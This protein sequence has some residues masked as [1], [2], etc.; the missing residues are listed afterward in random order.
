MKRSIKDAIAVS[1]K[2]VQ[3]VKRREEEQQVADREES[4]GLKSAMATLDALGPTFIALE[5]CSSALNLSMG[6]FQ[7]QLEGRLPAH[8]LFVD[9]FKSVFSQYIT[10]FMGLFTKAKHSVQQTLNNLRKAHHEAVVGRFRG[11]KEV[12]RLNQE[13]NDAIGHQR[14]LEIQ[15]LMS[16]FDSLPRWVSPTELYVPDPGAGS[17]HLLL[18]G[19]FVNTCIHPEGDAHLFR[20]NVTPTSE[21]VRIAIECAA[22]ENS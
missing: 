1:S 14:T 6:E 10:E 2:S 21:A 9:E 3:G 19:S 20:V 7:R 15:T 8:A 5:N 18:N 16:R 11:E 4:V 22:T 17:C 13:L 12:Q